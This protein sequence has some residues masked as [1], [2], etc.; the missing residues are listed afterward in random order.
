MWLM[1]AECD[2]VRN[3]RQLRLTL[4]SMRFAEVGSV[5]QSR[6]TNGTQD[7]TAHPAATPSPRRDVVIR[8]VVIG[9]APALILAGRDDLFCPLAQADRLHRGIARSKLVLFERSGHRSV[10]HRA[11]R[12]EEAQRL[13]SD[14]GV[15]RQPAAL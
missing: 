14:T 7:A 8:D 2:S 3:S 9:R 12:D 15:F 11:A 10:V 13:T 4:V 5:R 1:S 6:H